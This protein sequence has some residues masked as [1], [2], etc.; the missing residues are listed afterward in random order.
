MQNRKILQNQYSIPSKTVED[1]PLKKE[2]IIVTT[3]TTPQHN[4]NTVVGLDT[5]MTVQT[6]PTPPWPFII[7]YNVI[8]NNKQG[9]NNNID[10]NKNPNINN[11]KIT[12]NNKP[13]KKT[14]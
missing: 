4:L 14:I 5:E 6:P 11:N 3:P 8:S 1:W 9:H 12:N 2:T 10:N 7:T 13:I